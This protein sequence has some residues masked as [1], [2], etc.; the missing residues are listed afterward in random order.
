[1]N[2]IK[3]SKMNMRGFSYTIQEE[4]DCHI[5]QTTKYVNGFD[6]LHFVYFFPNSSE[7]IHMMFTHICWGSFTGTGAGLIPGL[8]PANERRCYKVTPSPIGWSQT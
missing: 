2:N 6:L 8:R 3:H 5:W 4:S 7:Q 1:M